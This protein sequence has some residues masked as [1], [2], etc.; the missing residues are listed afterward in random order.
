MKSFFRSSCGQEISRILWNHKDHFY[1]HNSPL[2][3]FM[4]SQINL[5]C[6]LILYI[7]TIQFNIILPSTYRCK[8]SIFCSY[9]ATKFLYI[10][11]ISL[12]R[13]LCCAHLTIIDFIIFAEYYKLWRTVLCNS[14]QMLLRA[15]ENVIN[16]FPYMWKTKFLIHSHQQIGCTSSTIHF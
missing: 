7:F 16:L 12:M 13:V 5:V 4:L 6:D 14:L 3:I 10:Y 15:L 1:A 11:L 8:G 2:I 9:F